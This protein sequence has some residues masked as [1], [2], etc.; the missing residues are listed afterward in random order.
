MILA[1]TAAPVTGYHARLSLTVTTP[2]DG[3]TITLYR[4]DLSGV[5]VPVLGA[6]GLLP[7]ST[8][9]DDVPSL[10]RPTWWRAVAS[11]GESAITAAPVTVESSLPVLADPRGGLAVQVTVSEW[12]EIQIDGS[13]TSIQVDVENQADDSTVW[14]LGGD[15]ARTATVTLR[16]DADLAMARAILS[17]G[18]AMLLRGSQPGIEDPW[19]VGRG[20]RERRVT[21]NAAD[22]RRYLVLDVG[23]PSAAPD[24]TVPVLGDTLADLAAAVSTTLL[25][26]S[27]TW[28]T[29]GEIAAAD[30][31]AM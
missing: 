28:A 22:W 17:S 27:T 16:C 18:R 4:D 14:I 7:V 2:T 31:K 5:L 24:P 29:L 19:L 6:S 12:S 30:L 15:G 3:S 20:R 25:D 8:V 23:I 26:I 10:N 11:T 9:V 21:A 1:I 13:A